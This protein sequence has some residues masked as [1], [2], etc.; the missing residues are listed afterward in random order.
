MYDWD[1]D[2][3][4]DFILIFIR[5]KNTILFMHVQI[6]SMNS[7]KKTAIKLFY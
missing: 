7:D 1:L 3:S 4:H 6:I 5:I 2:F